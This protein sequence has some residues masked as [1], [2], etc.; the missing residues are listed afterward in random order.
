M[1]NITLMIISILKN[2]SEL[3]PTTGNHRIK[4][5]SS[6]YLPSKNVYLAIFKKLTQPF[7]AKTTITSPLTVSFEPNPT[8]KTSKINAKISLKPQRPN[9]FE[10]QYPLQQYQILKEKLT[11]S[12]FRHRKRIPIYYL[13]PRNMVKT[14]RL[15]QNKQQPSNI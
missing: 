6:P 1:L 15:N 9:Y 3:T 7:N 5:N 11:F 13:P 12:S 10:S 2:I 14:R 8:N 4:E